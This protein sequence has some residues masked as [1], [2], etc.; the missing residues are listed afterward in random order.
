MNCVWWTVPKAIKTSS[1]PE[2]PGQKIRSRKSDVSIQSENEAK[3]IDKTQKESED[4]STQCEL[5][6]EEDS[7]Q[8]NKALEH[9][10]FLFAPQQF[11]D[12]VGFHGILSATADRA[13][14]Q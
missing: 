10:S 8:A 14:Q 6:M 7:W 3:A 1:V 2:E 4:A 12:N 5:S 13:N 9:V 11:V